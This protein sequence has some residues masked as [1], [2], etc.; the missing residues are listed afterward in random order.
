[1][2]RLTKLHDLASVSMYRRLFREL[3]TVECT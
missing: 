1:M 3:T 2:L